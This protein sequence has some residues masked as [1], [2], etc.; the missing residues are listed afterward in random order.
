L[1]SIGNLLAVGGGWLLALD[2]GTCNT[3]AAV[4]D[5]SAETGRSP[6]LVHF[7]D[8]T[9]LPSAV[10]LDD[11][12]KFVVGPHIPRSARGSARIEYT[13]KRLVGHGSVALAGQMIKD[14]D[15]VAAVMRYAVTEANKGFGA[16]SSHVVLTH[17]VAWE[18]PRRERLVQAAA[19]AGLDSVELLAEPMAAGIA[20]REHGQLEGIKDG[21]LI[22]V[23][24]FGG[25][26]LDV[27]LLERA[28]GSFAFYGQPEGEEYLGGE[29]VDDNLFAYVQS[30]LPESDQAAL[31]D[32]PASPDPLRWRAAERELRSEVRAAKERLAETARTELV[33]HPP[34]SV[35]SFVLTAAKLNEVAENSVRQSAAIV[36][37]LLKRNGVT[38]DKVAAMC[39]VGG[40]SKLA[41]VRRVLA[42]T[43]PGI[44]SAQ[45]IDPKGLVAYG[46]AVW[47]KDQV[48][49]S[50]GA[51]SK[52]GATG[53]K[54]QE[55]ARL[56]AELV[57]LM[58][59]SVVGARLGAVEELSVL[60]RSPDP[61]LALAARQ[62]LEHLVD[63]DSRRISERATQ[64]LA[65]VAVEG[66]TTGEA[67]VSPTSLA[68]A[69]RSSTDESAPPTQLPPPVP[70]EV[71]EI[72]TIIHEGRVSF[73]ASFS[74]DGSLVTGGEDKTVR[75]YEARTGREIATIK[76][77]RPVWSASFGANG[78][79]VVTTCAGDRTAW[80]SRAD[81]GRKRATVRHKS[82]V[83]SASFSPDGSV[84]L[85]SSMDKTT[86]VSDVTG[87][88]I[89]RITEEGKGWVSSASF[90]P[91]GK[92][93]M[94]VN[95]GTARIYET[96][97]GREIA[98]V[99]HQGRVGTTSFSPDGSLVMTVHD[100]IAR[101]SET[102]TGREIATI[103]HQG[104]VG[105]T[106]FSPDGSLVMTVHDKI[107]RISETRT[108]REIAT[109]NHQGQVNDASFSPEG[110][111]VVTCSDDHTARISEARTGREIARITHQKEVSKASFSPD[112][113][114]AMT[115][116]SDKTTRIWELDDSAN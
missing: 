62:A 82:M 92:M 76:H 53:S 2:F 1:Q 60:I 15:L 28:G 103:I 77:K 41:S 59:S 71:R 10:M 67:E 87:K 8:A 99:P 79:L 96:F 69:S 81:T 86:R 25:G 18:G 3:T 95:L 88:E 89:T 64:V 66:P 5:V 35:E 114:L 80:I 24:D 98:T 37:R 73:A 34:F 23:Y 14:V 43:F 17:P 83:L 16:P 11:D 12:G 68:E 116:T 42:E 111:L 51:D 40:S 52:A 22:V 31:A 104:Q 72:A 75:I 46:A 48:S 107:A 50:G 78:W 106:S 63:D 19:L 4:V 74:P 6:Q 27:V 30:Q 110:S 109:I 54:I 49:S 7:G 38:P 55:P 20:L 65:G 39:L 33:L 57:D 93:V 100:K 56:D 97:S 61:A 29:N 108:G 36:E 13:P 102:R 90:S 70:T 58:A 101:I 47:G 45:D 26:T 84:L 94:T 9:R 85:T 113:S 44:P 91:D 21:D 32:T 112:G 105:T 115:R